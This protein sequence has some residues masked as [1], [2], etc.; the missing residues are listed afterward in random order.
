M[1]S[2]VI[3]CGSRN[4]SDHTLLVKAFDEITGADLTVPIIITG[5]APGADALA[6]FE[7]HRRD[8]WVWACPADWNQW[9]KV[10]GPKRNQRMLEQTN[11]DLVIAFPLEGSKGTWDLVNRANF[12]SIPVKIYREKETRGENQPE[13]DA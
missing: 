9:G 1:A 8:W 13:K 12:L 4:F 3:V 6:E 10:A 5:A 11:P 2:R 7:A